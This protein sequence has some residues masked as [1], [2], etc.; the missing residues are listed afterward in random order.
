MPFVENAF[1][2]GDLQHDQVNLVI[3][4]STIGTMLCFSCRNEVAKNRV[5]AMGG[6]G[7]QNV[8][9]RLNL[10]LPYRHQLEI[11]EADDWF[12]VDLKMDYGNQ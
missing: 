1:K 8:R 5:D 11:K 4:I 9:K 12:F 2:H 10:L 6:I 3:E 7:I